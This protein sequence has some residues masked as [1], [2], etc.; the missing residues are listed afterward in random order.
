MHMPVG[1]YTYTTHRQEFCFQVAAEA[2]EFQKLR[3][4][5][6]FRQLE[7]CVRAMNS[8]TNIPKEN[9]KMRAKHIRHTPIHLV[10][11]NFSSLPAEDIYLQAIAI[12]KASIL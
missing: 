9:S 6:F 1:L 12:S 10:R 11:L 3:A 5:S 2:V 4:D 7:C 8:S